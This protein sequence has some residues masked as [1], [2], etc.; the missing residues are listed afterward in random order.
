MHWQ[1]CRLCKHLYQDFQRLLILF[2]LYSS[3]FR[4]GSG[5]AC[6]SIH[7]GFVIWNKGEAEDGEDSTAEQIAPETHWP[8]LRVLILVVKIK[9]TLIHIYI[10]VLEEKMQIFISTA[11]NCLLICMHKSLIICSF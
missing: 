1:Q 9:L 6:R 11:N 4:L 10:T 3:A 2:I 8:E 7:G 5:S